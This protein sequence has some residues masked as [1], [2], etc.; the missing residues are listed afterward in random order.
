MAICRTIPHYSDVN[1]HSII[2]YFN[3]REARYD[4][5]DAFAFQIPLVSQ[6]ENLHSCGKLCLAI[7]RLDVPH[8]A[9]WR[10]REM[11][12]LPTISSIFTPLGRKLIKMESTSARSS[13]I[14]S[15]SDTP[16]AVFH[17]INVST[18]RHLT[19]DL[20]SSKFLLV[21]PPPFSSKPPQYHSSLSLFLS[22]VGKSPL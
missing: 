2:H 10:V 21:M 22:L 19:L 18:R 15:C 12:K 1:H 17:G 7:L 13:P 20:I 9:F 5:I 11:P 6:F 16:D 14:C 4:T 3:N 8:K